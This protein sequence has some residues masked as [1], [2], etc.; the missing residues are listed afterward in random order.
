[1]LLGFSAVNTGNNLL[2]LVVAAMLGFM[3]VS[4]IVG[5]TNIRGLKLQVVFPDE[6]YTGTD[7]LAVVRL[8]NA[9]RFMPSF[10]L[11]I[12]IRGASVD[13]NYIGGSSTETDSV[14]VRFPDRGRHPLGEAQVF[15]PF[16]VNFF[17]RCNRLRLDQACL[18]FPAPRRVSQVRAADQG[19]RYMNLPALNKGLEGDLTGIRDYAGG[20]PLKTIH[21]RLSAKHPQMK[22]KE[23]SAAGGEPVIL[24]LD[25]L[26][27]VTLNG[28]LSA[29]AYL[30]NSLIRSNRPVGL[31][32]RDRIIEPGVTKT[33]RLRLLTELA[34]YDQN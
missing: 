1:M 15:S 14:V 34:L 23:M 4:G 20:D 10:L 33:H 22:V 12:S 2:F 16:P 25:F 13:F 9:K 3:A 30:V 32:I 21:W 11:Q 6:V 8:T 17:V 5:W 29:A 28:R 24:D 18:V 31:R 26:P 19:Q 7:T 27:D